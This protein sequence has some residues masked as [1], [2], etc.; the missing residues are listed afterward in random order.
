MPVGE[1]S[2]EQFELAQLPSSCNV[3]D[4]GIPKDS[5]TILRPSLPQGLES[6]ERHGVLQAAAEALPTRSKSVRFS[7]TRS[8]Q[9]RS[10]QARSSA[11][12]P[13]SQPP[14]PLARRSPPT[15]T[16][17][18]STGSGR[19]WSNLTRNPGGGDPLFREVEYLPGEVGKRSPSK[20]PRQRG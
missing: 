16:A 13:R 15:A 18:N 3:E 1:G 2:I 14:S 17:G 4:P 8:S 19:S 20:S 10:S 12:A 5:Q 11:S 9:G 7:Q 6:W